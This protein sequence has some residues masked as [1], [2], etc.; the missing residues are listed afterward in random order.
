MPR[1]QSGTPTCALVHG[2]SPTWLNGRTSSSLLSSCPSGAE[3]TRKVLATNTPPGRSTLEISARAAC[4]HDGLLV[5]RGKPPVRRQLQR[6]LL[7]SADQAADKSGGAAVRLL[8]ERGMPPVCRQLQRLL[9][10]SADQAADESGGAAVGLLVERGMPLVCRQ[11][12][13]L[14]LTSA[15]Q[16]ADKSGG[17]AVGLLVERTIQNSRCV[18][19]A[20]VRVEGGGVHN[21]PHLS[22]PVPH[23]SPPNPVRTCGFGQQCRAAPACTAARLPVANG[24][25]PTSARSS[26]IGVAPPSEPSSLKYERACCSIVSEKSAAITPEKRP[27]LAKR[28][29]NRPLPQLMSSRVSPYAGCRKSSA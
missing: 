10:T 15:D 24:S 5:E 6:R 11:L 26:V 7:T 25:L 21:D 28:R 3:A 13:R 1:Q 8:V 18:L 23:Q 2:A 22:P 20:V 14:L 4:V 27:D 19:R 17:A 9:L 12:Q 16:A 29:E